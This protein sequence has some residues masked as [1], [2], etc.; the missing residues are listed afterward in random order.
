MFEKVQKGREQVDSAVGA[1]WLGVLGATEG[2]L[3]I[4][5]THSHLTDEDAEAIG[6]KDWV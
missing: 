1:D 2:T 4:N 5:R 3:R 6:V